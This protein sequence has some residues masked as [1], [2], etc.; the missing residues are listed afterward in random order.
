MVSQLNRQLPHLNDLPAIHVR[1]WLRLVLLLL[2]HVGFAGNLDGGEYEWSSHSACLTL[3]NRSLSS[4]TAKDGVEG[5]PRSITN[6]WPNEVPWAHS[7]ESRLAPASAGF[8][9]LY[10][11][12]TG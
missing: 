12:S 6:S 2:R 1:A 3:R 7:S 10:S 5:E 8:W 4:C 11:L 9:M